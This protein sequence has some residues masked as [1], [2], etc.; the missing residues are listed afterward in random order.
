MRR[1]RVCKTGNPV[2]RLLRCLLE[3]LI[4]PGLL[5]GCGDGGQHGPDGGAPMVVD[6]RH[7]GVRDAPAGDGPGMP[8]VEPPPWPARELACEDN[9]DNDGDTATDCEDDDCAAEAA[10]AFAPP[11]DRTVARGFHDSVRFLYEGPQA[12]QIGADPSVGAATDAGIE[13]ASQLI[14]NGGNIDC[15]DW[16]GVMS[17][18]VGGLGPGA[19]GGAL[20]KAFTTAKSLRK[21]AKGGTTGWEAVPASPGG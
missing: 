14:D 9:L 13:L 11:L 3:A 1:Q 6:A 8:P 4:L 12:V 7:A 17:S 5:A 2:R 19:L 16:G 21:A 10:C 20:G 15:L 18:G